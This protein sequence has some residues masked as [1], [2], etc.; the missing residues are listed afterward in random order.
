MPHH[1]QNRPAMSLFTGRGERKYLCAAERERFYAAL[2]T[3]ADLK[4]R[5]F[6]ETIYWTGCRPSEALALTA[7]NIDLDDGVVVIR[8]LKKR[9]PLKGRHFRPVP[10]PRA[11][12]RDLDRVHDLRHW[13]AQP[14]G[15]AQTR[16]WPFSRTTGWKRVRAVMEAA[17]IGGIKAS[18]KG[19]RHAYGVHAALSRVPES[20][21][22]TWL[23]HANIAT[24]EIYL[25]MAAHEDRAMAQR[26]WA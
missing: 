23:G 13:Q 12:L 24:T 22:K 25:D 19:L 17:Q 15:G 1:D 18:A 2:D 21:I 4:D 14:G 16:L 10:V 8:S 7:L 20:R 6:C 9:G 3:L 5:T 26:M 11:F